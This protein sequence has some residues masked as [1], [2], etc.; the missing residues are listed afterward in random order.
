MRGWMRVFLVIA[1]ILLSLLVGL[2]VCKDHILQWAFVKVQTRI[3]DTYRADL[4]V[5][6]FELEGLDNVR[7]K[8]ITLQPQGADTFL[9]IA[10]A[11]M[12]ISLPSLL[13]GKVDFNQIR[14]DGAN[15]TI[16]N[17]ED[18][19]NLVFLR[20][21]GRSKNV[22][23][24]SP[25][26]GFRER[27]DDW[28]KKLFRFL[29]TAFEA[30]NIRILYQDTTRTESV[31]IPSFSYDL[32][33]LSGALINQKTSDTL[34]IEGTVLKKKE[35]YQCTLRTAGNDTTYLPFLDHENGLKC[36]FHSI[37]A[38]LKFDNNSDQS[39]LT[40]VAALEDFHLN[41]WRLARED[42]VLSFAKF[43]GSFN[44]TD[45]AAEL[46][47]S[48]TI[49]LG[50]SQC[51]IFARYDLM[52]DTTFALAL[53]MPEMPAD[54]FF[55]ALPGGMFNTLKGISCSGTL[56]YDL[57]FAIHT[58]NPDSLLFYSAMKQKNLHVQHFGEDNYTRI[59][60][61]FSY[62]AYDKDRFVR[63]LT[64]GPENPNFTPLDQMSAFLPQAVLQAEDPSFMQHRGFYLDAFRESIAKN[65]KEHRFAR[66]GSTISMQLVKNVF[67]SRDKTVSRKAEEALIV[68]LIE[69]LGLVSKDRMLEVY[70]NAIEWGPN[71]YGIGEAS[72]FYFDKRPSQLSL[73]ESIFMASIIPR[74]KLFQY[75]FDKQ[76]QLRASLNSY[77]KII[78]ERMVWRGVLNPSDT[79]GLTPQVTLHG[80]ALRMVTP[81]DSVLSEPD[82]T[83]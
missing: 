38:D 56:A 68:Y 47:S 41:H 62:D 42:V 6:S 4:Q 77:F 18:R 75:Q 74:P 60:S 66:G 63:R 69:N 53:H 13:S 44:F 57:T 33:S 52:P 73:Q 26:S 34:F 50:S 83:D 54:S 20:S 7:L 78:S 2:Y 67:L 21:V 39:R 48:S 12:K 71:V 37:S 19:N 17:Q 10:E 65:Y 51:K 35:A 32:H 30:K 82:E 79:V 76:G 80:P 45:N 49:K 25:P 9:R 29:N 23:S 61:S 11:D 22:T 43:D 27:A 81:R 70:L 24:S 55:Q 5:G 64:I 59:N 28:E 46:D 3:H 31:Y 16:Y 1:L 58:N 8:N 15:F 36:R 14:I 72:R 40:I